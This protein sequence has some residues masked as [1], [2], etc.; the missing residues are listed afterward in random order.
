MDATGIRE[1]GVRLTSIRSTVGLSG[2]EQ[3]R[4]IDLIS[5]GDNAVLLPSTRITVYLAVM[6]RAA[7]GLPGDEQE[8]TTVGNMALF[9]ETTIDVPSG[10]WGFVNF[11]DIGAHRLG[12]WHRFLVADLIGLTD[13]ADGNMPSTANSLTFLAN[14]ETYFFIGQTSGDKVLVGSSSAGVQPG[15]VRIRSN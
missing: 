4:L 6:A 2:L 15:T 8:D 5:Q 10:T 1:L 11:G 7:G 12:E 14:E 9:D 13:A 3:I